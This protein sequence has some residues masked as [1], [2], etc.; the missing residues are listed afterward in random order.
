M[1]W[2]AYADDL[3]EAI[4]TALTARGAQ[5]AHVKLFIGR[6]HHVL[7]VGQGLTGNLTCNQG[8]A[9]VRGRLDPV[10]DKSVMRINA[11]V[12]IAPDELRAIV[13]GALRGERR[14]A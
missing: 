2:R 6:G 7:M 1:D 5:I 9:S 8:P 3:L 12:H 11:R 4:R 13:E 14:A 10:T